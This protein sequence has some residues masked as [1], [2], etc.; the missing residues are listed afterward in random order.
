M[1]V[2]NAPVTAE[3]ATEEKAKKKRKKTM[4]HALVII[5]AII[6]VVTVLTWII[7]GGVYLQQDAN[8]VWQGTEGFDESTGSKVYVQEAYYNM[9]KTQKIG[10]WAM[11]TYIVDGF[12]SAQ[13]II[14]LILCAYATLYLLQKTGALDAAIASCARLVGKKPAAAP[15]IIAIVMFIFAFWATTGTMSYEEIVAFLPVFVALSLALGYDPMVGA[16]MSVCAVGFG[17]SVGV[18]NPF[19]TGTAQS[20]AG[21]EMFSGSGYRLI[22]LLVTTGIL[23]AYTLLYAA[24]VK[25][26]P[27]KSITADIDFSDQHMDDERLNSRFD[28]KKILSL[29]CL[30]AMIGVMAWGLATQGWYVEEITAL[31]IVLAIALGIVNLWSPSKVAK[32]WVEGLG[33][34]VLP[35]IACGFARS[36]LFILAYGCIQDPI[37][38]WA[39]NL[40]ATLGLYG[41]AVGM[42]LFQSLLNFLIPSGSSQAFVTM[43][44]MAPI[45]EVIG[46]SKQVAVLAFQFGDGFSNLLWPTAGA[47]IVSI[48]A[49]IPIG[50]YYKWFLPLFAIIFVVMVAFLWIAISIGL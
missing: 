33:K 14:F 43:P 12:A 49:G 34:A 13:N 18:W 39:S 25:K 17:F 24:R 23:V 36:I 5:L 21:I 2:K 8:G 28:T 40:L 27:A 41:A 29:V 37:I 31:F 47:V 45:A 1:E 6:L 3:T 4:P 48:M 42:L 10:L 50:R 38:H 9:G 22:V 19:T 16:S 44:L 46:M 35:A 32:I 15:L 20:I 11:F 7:P 30:A 26:D